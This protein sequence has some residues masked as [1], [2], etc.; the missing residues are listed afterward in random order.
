VRA[1]EASLAVWHRLVGSV[2]QLPLLL[3]AACRP[4]PKRAELVALRRAVAGSGVLIELAALPP[5]PVLELVGGLVG[6]TTVGPGLARA[7]AQAA[8]NP[9]YVREVVDGLGREG[10]L[11]RTGGAVEL[12]GPEPNATVRRGARGS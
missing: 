7:V 3:V 12:T 11:T 5:K 6:A 1:D 10:R 2:A 9:L 8:G 4:L